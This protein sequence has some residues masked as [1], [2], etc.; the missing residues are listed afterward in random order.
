MKSK[1]GGFTIQLGILTNSSLEERSIDGFNR[2]N[3]GKAQSSL[4]VVHHCRGFHAKII[5]AR[6][7]NW[8]HHDSGICDK[9]T[10]R[11]LK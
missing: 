9:D 1:K 7:Y 4:K 3:Q 8:E 5:I 11:D 2:D 10:I 6:N